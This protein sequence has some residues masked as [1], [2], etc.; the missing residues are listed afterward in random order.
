MKRIIEQGMRL[1]GTV[2]IVLKSPD[3]KVKTH[4]VHHNMIVNAG[5]DL[6]NTLMRAG[7]GNY[8]NVLG[9][10]WNDPDAA[11]ITLAVGDLDFQN[12]TNQDFK[13]GGDVTITKITDKSWKL[14]AT[15]GAGEP[16]PGGSGWPIPIRGIGAYYQAL[17]D[18]IFSGIVR[19]PL[20]KEDIDELII[21]YTFTMA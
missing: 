11:T 20:S 12:F 19:A 5:F 16:T 7:T 17:L 1:I 10:V 9:L 2:E 13:S 21:T 8:P 4:D 6:I 15:W 14:E 3:G 18:K